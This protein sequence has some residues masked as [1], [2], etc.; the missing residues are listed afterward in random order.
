MSSNGSASEDWKELL[1]ALKTIGERIAAFFLLVLVILFILHWISVSFRYDNPS[2]WYS[3]SLWDSAFMVKDD[4]DVI[5]TCPTKGWIWPALLLRTDRNTV[6]FGT[7][8]KGNVV[9]IDLRRGNASEQ[10]CALIYD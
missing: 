7:P 8:S 4:L 2:P 10:V 1:Q 6:T 5:V 3:T 9:V